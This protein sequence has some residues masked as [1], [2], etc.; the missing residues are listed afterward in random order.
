VKGQRRRIGGQIVASELDTASD[1]LDP[2]GVAVVA[3]RAHM[4]VTNALVVKQTGGAS[5]P[6]LA[7]D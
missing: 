6:D 1:F 5:D 2:A 3:I 4:A 7:V